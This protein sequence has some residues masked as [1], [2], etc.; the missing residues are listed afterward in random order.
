MKHRVIISLLC[1][2]GFFKEFRPITPFLTPLLIS[3]EKGFTKEEIYEYVY[4]IWAYAHFIFSIPIVLFTDYLNFKP[5]LVIESLSLIGTGILLTFGNTL[6]LI[7]MTQ[8]TYGCATAS[9]IAFMS[10]LYTKVDD[11]EIPFVTGL[12]RGV[13]LLS[14]C[15]CTLFGQICISMKWTNLQFINQLTLIMSVLGLPFV[16]LAII[17]GINC[18]KRNEEERF[19]EKISLKEVKMNERVRKNSLN[20]LE[21]FVYV[22]KNL[23]EFNTLFIWSIWWIITTSLIYQMY[24]Y[25]QVHWTPLQENSGNIYNGLVEFINTLLGAFVTLIFSRIRINWKK[26]TEQITIILS[27][28][29]SIFF[30]LLSTIENIYGSYILY[31]LINVTYLFFIAVASTVL[32]SIIDV[33]GIGLIFGIIS[34][35]SSLLQSLLGFL[36]INGNIWSFSTK[37]Q[38]SVYSIIFLFLSITFILI[39][40]LKCI[41]VKKH[42]DI[43]G[44]IEINNDIKFRNINLD[45]IPENVFEEL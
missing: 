35:L 21:R 20:L 1:L 13:I 11:K 16:V 18:K 25:I 29:F 30:W 4:P 7:Q 39:S 33:N 2:Y 9:E 44:D 22:K 10:Y 17:P 42:K 38:F 32:A 26:F 37:D 15:M 34:L 6:R 5:I 23:S 36:L 19:E 40:F 24:N 31:I 28:F 27:I 12:I 8:I 45:T 14:K 3:K 43:N 41:I